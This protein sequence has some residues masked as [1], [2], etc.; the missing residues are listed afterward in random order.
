MQNVQN[1]KDKAGKYLGLAA[2]VVIAVIMA[3][4]FFTHRSAP[5]AQKSVAEVSVADTAVNPLNLNMAI[6]T[7]EPLPPPPIKAMPPPPSVLA[8]NM[9]FVLAQQ[10]D[11]SRL[12]S[13]TQVYNVD[14]NAS[15][16]AAASNMSDL[17][18]NFLQQAANT[19]VVTVNAKQNTQ[20]DYKILQGKLITAIL[21][22]SINSD[23]PGMVRAVVS[24]DIYSDTG[25]FIL[26]P[27]G[28]RLIGVY[29][30]GVVTGQTRVMV[31]WTRAITPQHLDIALGSPSADALGQSGM[32]GSVDNHF[33]QIF[34]TSALLSVLGAT[35]G[36][37]DM[38]GNNHSLA[39]NPYQA[40]VTQGVLNAS[41]NVLQS[42]A[43]IKPTIRVPQGDVIQVFVARDL[44]F[45]RLS[46]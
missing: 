8:Q 28:T 17:G 36:S 14:S 12:K 45:S 34:G 44:D 41:G 7:P 22:T 32:T 27:K 38:G 39:G 33:W 24:K 25:R 42:R 30:S 19:G 46:R 21:E 20:M 16:S 35:A 11:A 37:I 13:P 18:N 9:N 5:V 29:N 1:K 4:G 40:A 3:Q 15:S 26:V 10:S 6:N 31:V 2:F 43:N 23:L